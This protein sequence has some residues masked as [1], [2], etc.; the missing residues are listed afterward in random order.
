MN[1]KAIDS[2]LG[3]LWAFDYFII[4]IFALITVK[5]TNKIFK[6]INVMLE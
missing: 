1:M 4:I 3:V 2:M 6:E 5:E